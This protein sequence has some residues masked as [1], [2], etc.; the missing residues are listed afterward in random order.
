VLYNAT[1]YRDADGN[2]SG[3]FAAARDVTAQRQAAQYARSLIEASLDPLV[4]ISPDGVIT[5]VNEATILATGVPRERLI[6]ADFSDYF[7]EPEKA[8]QGYRE[9]FSR[10]FVTDYPL[11][12][13]RQ[14]GHLTDVLYNAAVYRDVDGNVSG[15][16]AA[17]RDITERKRAEE[18]VRTLNAEL[19]QRVAD[20]T[21]ELVAANREM[22]AFTYSVSHDLRAPLRAMDGFSLALLEDYRDR[23]D[24][25]GR[26]FLRVIRESS[27]T[28]A[29]LIDDLLTLSRVS[30]AGLRREP[31]DMSGMVTGIAEQLRQA[32]PERQVSFVVAPGVTAQGD[33]RL[34]RQVLQN[35]LQNAWKFTSKHPRATVE[36]GTTER[37]GRRAY[38]VRD[39]GAGF[40]PRYVHK[41]F[42]VFQRLHGADEFEGTGIGLAIVQRIIHRHGGQ[43][44]AEGGI[45]DGATFSFT[46]E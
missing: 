23:L 34:V 42:G 43:V 35:L 8:R 39:D 13:R 46:L 31:I 1:V 45:E 24:D 6:G 11:T 28:M 25:Q 27:Q 40:D 3:V 5:D 18:E 38:Y 32:E 44:W 21:A 4:T 16:F 41:L 9:V 37:E 26:E 20:R 7:T 10:G 33:A 19:E 36:F 15:V 12:I 30:R 22:E 29:Q 2:V 14:D 17:A